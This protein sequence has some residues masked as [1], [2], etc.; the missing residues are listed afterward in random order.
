MLRTYISADHLHGSYYFGG[1][2]PVKGLFNPRSYGKFVQI[3]NP[4][5]F[6]VAA[7]RKDKKINL[8][9]DIIDIKQYQN[10]A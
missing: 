1:H 5:K 6:V 2:R 8:K 4:N 3:H 7:I 9:R 10:E